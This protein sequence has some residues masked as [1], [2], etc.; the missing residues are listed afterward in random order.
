MIETKIAIRELLDNRSNVSFLMILKI[1]KECDVSD[2]EREM[3]IE[4][5][6]PHMK[7]WSNEEYRS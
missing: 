6:G 2:S 1:I 3:L 5:C 7:D 4:Y